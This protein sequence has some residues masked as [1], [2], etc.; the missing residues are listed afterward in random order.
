M[1]IGSVVLV[2]LLVLAAGCGGGSDDD[3]GGGKPAGTTPAA[4]SGPPVGD[5]G[6]REAAD[7]FATCFKEPGFRA[8]RDASARQPAEVVAEAK[9]YQVEGMLMS[10]DGGVN[11]FFIQ[12]FDSE[13]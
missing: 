12:F 1:R 8:I 10:S 6:G 3:S 13:A 4:Q 7:A 9:G 2:L 5:K 11:S